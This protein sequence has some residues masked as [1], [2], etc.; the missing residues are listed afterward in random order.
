MSSRISINNIL[1][2]KKRGEK[3]VMLT[4]YDY[5]LAACLDEVGVD[6]I[7]VGDSVA[8][9][10]LG[11][12]STLD[13]DIEVMLHHTKAVSRAVKRAM[14]VGD[15]PFASLQAGPAVALSHAKRFINEAGADA[16]KVEWFD[17][18]AELVEKMVKAGIPVMGHAG[19]TPQTAEALG[20][21]KVQGKD[22][23]AAARILSHAKTLEE[24]GCFSVVLECVPARLGEFISRQLKI[25][26]ISIGAGAGC[27]GQVL[28]TQDILGLSDRFHPKFVKTYA[29]IGAVIKEG[30]TRFEDD[31]RAGRFPADEQSY[32]MSDEEFKKFLE[33]VK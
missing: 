9:V 28:V 24:K 12:E 14:V 30:I 7:L 22:A 23:A 2:K 27:D 31:V 10:V 8:N 16:V 11:L 1:Q 15:M 18:C 21:F 3:I 20:G 4:A 13:V 6:I 17:G 25:P 5:P 29:N 26:T 19:L 33:A 32:S